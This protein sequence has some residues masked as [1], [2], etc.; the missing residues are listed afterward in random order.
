M[1]R[2]GSQTEVCPLNSKMHRLKS[3][4]LSTVEKARQGSVQKPP[5]P[6]QL[7]SGDNTP[8]ALATARTGRRGGGDSKESDP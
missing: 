8:Q 1:M 3:V 5:L 2:L 4:S 6:A 7:L